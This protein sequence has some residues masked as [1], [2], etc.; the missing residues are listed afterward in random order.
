MRISKFLIF[1]CLSLI[2]FGSF[3]QNHTLG[4]GAGGATFGGETS[5]D[6][7]SN[8]TDIGIQSQLYYAFAFKDPRWQ[9]MAQLVYSKISAGVDIDSDGK[10]INYTTNS[11]H[12]LGAVGLRFYFDSYTRRY[13]PRFGHSAPFIGAH[14]G[15]T[16]FSNE[17]SSATFTDEDIRYVSSGT[18]ND[19]AFLGELGYRFYLS[20][21]WSIEANAN[22]RTGTNDLWDGFR[23]G[24]EYNDWI[25]SLSLGF[26]LNL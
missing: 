20:K 12:F 14:I 22:F 10:L 17:A 26:A 23:G 1:I 4:F 3:A 11:E 2:S 5:T 9:L 24:T 25:L 16:S 21:I 7:A 19:I 8:M 18:Y 15:G 13:L 6:F